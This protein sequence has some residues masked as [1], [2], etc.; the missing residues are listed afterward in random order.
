M[1]IYI[2]SFICRNSHFS[3]MYFATLPINFDWLKL[4]R[5]RLFVMLNECAS[6]AKDGNV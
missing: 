2:S 4:Y 6:I 3:M 5:R 1:H